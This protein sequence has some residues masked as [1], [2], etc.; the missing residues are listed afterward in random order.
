MSKMCSFKLIWNLSG[1]MMKILTFVQMNIFVFN[2]SKMCLF[3]LILICGI[4]MKI[5]AL[6]KMNM[7]VFIWSKMCS[8]EL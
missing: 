1:K 4:I 8:F 5:L 7:F 2:C 3:E 6:N